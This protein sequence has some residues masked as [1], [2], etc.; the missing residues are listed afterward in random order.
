MRFVDANR[1]RPSVGLLRR[2]H[3]ESVF[4]SARARRDPLL[5]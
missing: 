1:L 3:V 2:P 5:C 4:L